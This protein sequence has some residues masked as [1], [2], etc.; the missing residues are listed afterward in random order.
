MRK[1]QPQG[2]YVEKSDKNR[3]IHV[4]PINDL[5]KHQVEGKPCPCHPKVNIG[6]YCAKTGLMTEYASV[7][8][9]HNAW[10]KRK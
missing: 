1:N 8:I 7:I 10:D 4:Y 3:P 2:E 9:I 5:R 6:K